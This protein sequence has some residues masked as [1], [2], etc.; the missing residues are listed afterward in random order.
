AFSLLLQGPALYLYL[1]SLSEDIVLLQWGNVIHLVPAL[2]GALVLLVFGID[3]I[4]WQPVTQLDGAEKNAVAFV[5][6]LVKISPVVYI[7]AS[8]V[9]EYRLR[10]HLRHIYSAISESE[11]KLADVV[12]AG[13]CLHWCWSLFAYLLE[14]VV[15]R[16]VSDNL[17]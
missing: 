10:E 15:S 2:V 11:L 12:L 9:A 6:A 14:G 5:W 7:I 13:F 8:V 1:R 4:E 17:G 16:S 3:S